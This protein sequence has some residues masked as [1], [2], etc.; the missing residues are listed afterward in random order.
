[1]RGPVWACWPTRRWGWGFGVWLSARRHVALTAAVRLPCLACHRSCHLKMV[2]P[3]QA[4][5]YSNRF[6]WH[7]AVQHPYEAGSRAGGLRASD[8]WFHLVQAHARCC[9]SCCHSA[10]CS[11]QPGCDKL[12]VT[13]ALPIFPTHHC[14]PCP[15]SGPAQAIPRRPTVAVSQGRC[16]TRA[17][18]AASGADWCVSP[19]GLSGCQL[20]RLALHTGMGCRMCQALE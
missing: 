8:G 15:P 13:R 10:S 17:G 12:Q 3:L 1:M 16:R 14:S 19:P 4:A 2:P 18:P 9:L 11:Q 20:Q 7:K 5:P 6:W